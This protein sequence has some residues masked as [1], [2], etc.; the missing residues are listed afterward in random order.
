MPSATSWGEMKC[1]LMKQPIVPITLLSLLTAFANLHAAGPDAGFGAYHTRLG[2]SPGGD[3]G[4]YEDLIVT[5]GHTNRLE[6]TRANGYQPQWRTAGGVHRVENVI[7]NTTEDPN[8]NY[9]YVRLIE[10]GPAKIVVHW[11]HF[12][13]I[14]TLTMDSKPASHDELT[15]TAWVALDT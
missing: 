1:D 8:C 15:V 4:K 6:F 11:H 9:S 12:R 3:I 7:P 5:L 13:D 14:E 10:N 2:P